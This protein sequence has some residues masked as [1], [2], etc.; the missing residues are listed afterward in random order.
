MAKTAEAAKSLPLA[1]L[2]ASPHCIYTGSIG[3]IKDGSAATTHFFL[4]FKWLYALIRR[5][6]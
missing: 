6:K 1:S 5:I 2:E 3:S 4:F